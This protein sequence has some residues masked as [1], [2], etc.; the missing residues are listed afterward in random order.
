MQTLSRILLLSIS[1]GLFQ[2][3]FRL[4]ATL[5]RIAAHSLLQCFMRSYANTSPALLFCWRRSSLIS[6]A[7]D[8]LNY[9]ISIKSCFNFGSHNAG[10][11]LEKAIRLLS[12]FINYS[13][14]RLA[15]STNS[16]DRMI[17]LNGM[18]K[19]KILS[20]GRNQIKKVIS[21]AIMRCSSMSSL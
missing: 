5:W 19:L 10:Y 2:T 14:R 16:I 6:S 11:K 12:V 3:L 9:H 17:P 18:A 20:L 4:N 21:P 7:Y 1:M 8:T 13:I 15:L